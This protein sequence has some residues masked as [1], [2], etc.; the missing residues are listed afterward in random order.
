[1]SR[2]VATV[3]VCGF[4][5]TLR[6]YDEGGRYDFKPRTRTL[7]QPT[8]KPRNF[9]RYA[10]DCHRVSLLFEHYPSR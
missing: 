10:L 1:M 8:K 9:G 4:F 6:Y 2:D 5:I 7:G 3:G